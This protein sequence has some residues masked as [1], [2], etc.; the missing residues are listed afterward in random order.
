VRRSSAFTGLDP[1]IKPVPVGPDGLKEREFDLRDRVSSGA[2]G[3]ELMAL[4]FSEEAITA[5]ASAAIP[6]FGI[7]ASGSSNLGS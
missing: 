5:P 3:K 2:T 6:R 4:G 7:Y 1:V